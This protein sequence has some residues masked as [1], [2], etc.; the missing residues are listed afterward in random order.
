MSFPPPEAT[1]GTELAC[2]H[3]IDANMWQPEDFPD[4]LADFGNGPPFA[5]IVK[6]VILFN[7]KRWE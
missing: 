2:W 5:R 1:E 3:G 7:A 6:A 4:F